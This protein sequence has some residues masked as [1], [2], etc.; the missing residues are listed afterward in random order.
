VIEFARFINYHVGKMRAY[1]QNLFNSKQNS[2]ID[3]NTFIYQVAN[4]SEVII[5]LANDYIQNLGSSQAKKVQGECHSILTEKDKKVRN[6]KVKK[7]REKLL[8]EEKE[9]KGD[10][11]SSS[12]Y[13]MKNTIDLITVI[14][15]TKKKM[16]II[17]PTSGRIPGSLD[18]FLSNC[19]IDCMKKSIFIVEKLNEAQRDHLF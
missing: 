6:E 14:H 9:N 12:T 5:E 8:R 15:F 1:L 4:L 10:N 11:S 16:Y 19:N 3:T 13:D 18:H 2:K 17:K 7:Y